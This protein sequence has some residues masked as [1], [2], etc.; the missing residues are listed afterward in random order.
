MQY[1]VKLK[2][3]SPL[4][5]IERC[6]LKWGRGNLE[7]QKG[8]KLTNSATSRNYDYATIY[9]PCSIFLSAMA[10]IYA[11]SRIAGAAKVQTL[12]ILK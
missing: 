10:V 9:I 5:S 11:I 3:G 12:P 6:T 7:N 1:R 2:F 4:G 8:Q